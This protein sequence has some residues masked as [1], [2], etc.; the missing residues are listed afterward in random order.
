MKNDTGNS[1]NH[2]SSS[3][4]DDFMKAVSLKRRA[5]PQIDAD[6]LI[7]II[8]FVGIVVILL[9]SYI[10]ILFLR[11]KTLRTKRNI[12]PINLT[13]SDAVVGFFVIPMFVTTEE[14]HRSVTKKTFLTVYRMHHKGGVL[15][16]FNTLVCIY[17][18]TAVIADRAVAICLP[19]KYRRDFTTR[20]ASVVVVLIW[21]LSAI[22]ACLSFAIYK[23]LYD[24]DEISNAIDLLVLM[25]NIETN[26]SKYGFYQHAFYGLC[27]TGAVISGFSLLVKSVVINRTLRRKHQ[28]NSV[29]S[30]QG[31][32]PEELK[33]AYMLGLMFSAVLL[34]IISIVYLHKS[35][36]SKA[37]YMGMY[38]GRFSLSIVNAVLYT[39]LKQDMRAK[40]KEDAKKAKDVFRRCWQFCCCKSK[41][42]VA[43]DLPIKISQTEGSFTV[44]LPM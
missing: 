23:P 9:N 28:R 11:F 12:F 18:L 4:Y 42:K 19:F 43:Q 32:K 30:R 17:S 26:L 41:R 25:V 16:L 7:Y 24:A 33:A 39:L 21:I 3:S 8:I 36:R 2:N 5:F 6:F 22:F 38:I 40:C 34:W 35:Q 14:L 15:L 27:V 44:D 31:G 29:S 37:L 1:T 10:I 13:I 20:K